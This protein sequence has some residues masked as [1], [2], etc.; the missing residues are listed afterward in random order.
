MIRKAQAGSHMPPCMASF[1][2]SL[3]EGEFLNNL[4]DL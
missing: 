3:H 1:S 4:H 2:P